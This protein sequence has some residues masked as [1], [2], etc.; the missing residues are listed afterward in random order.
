M[1]G[2]PSRR[3]LVRHMIEQGLSERWAL[4]VIGMSPSAYRYRPA[5]DRN[6]ALRERIIALAQRHRRY[7]AGMIYLKLRQAGEIVNHKRV[8]R[9]YAEAGLA[10]AKEDSDCGSPPAAASPGS[11]STVVDGFRVRPDGRG[12]QHQEPDDRR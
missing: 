8:D 5:A 9:L 12:A 2:A 4:R 11:Q 7:G 1:V 3:D 6:A 10:Q